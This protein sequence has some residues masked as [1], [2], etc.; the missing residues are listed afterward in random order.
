MNAKTL[1][2][3]KMPNQGGFIIKYPEK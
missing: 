1:A 2:K 3:V